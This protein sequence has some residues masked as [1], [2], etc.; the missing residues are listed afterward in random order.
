MTA[1]R[2]RMIATMQLRGLSDNTQRAY[3]QAIQLLAQHYSN[4]M[5]AKNYMYIWGFG[6]SKYVS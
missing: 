3:L 2:R 1:L 6:K 5:T 4:P